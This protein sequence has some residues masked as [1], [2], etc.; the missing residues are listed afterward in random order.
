MVGNI[1]HFRDLDVLRTFLVLALSEGISRQELVKRLDLGEGTIRSILA[2]LKEKQCIVSTQQGHILTL[3]G[4]QLY[5]FL[6]KIISQPKSIVLHPYDHL[7]SI[8]VV[9]KDTL[10]LDYKH[11]KL[12]DHAVKNGAEGAVLLHSKKDRLDVGFDCK[13]DFTYLRKHFEELEDGHT[14]ITTFSTSTK[15]AEAGA[16]AV[17]LEVSKEM[18][19]VIQQLC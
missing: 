17:V 10:T 15:N 9:Y 18:K 4:K 12:R 3:K 14:L 2:I 7:K 8:G 6:N 11:Y 1:P 13:D 5:T 19:K 16:L